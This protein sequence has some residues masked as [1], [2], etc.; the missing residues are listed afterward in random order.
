MSER[1]IKFIPGP[2]ADFLMTK[3]YC[4]ALLALVA[5]RARREPG[6]P[7]GLEPGEA[8]I[9]DW[10][11]IGASRQEY[12][13]ALKILVTR[14]HFTVSET[15]R[16]RKKSTTGVTT[17]GTKVK[18]I[19]SSVYDLNLQESNH[20]ANHCPTTAQPLTNHEQERRKNEEER[21]KKRAIVSEKE[22]KIVR[23]SFRSP[24]SYQEDLKNLNEFALAMNLDI[25]CKDFGYWIKKYG[26]EKIDL[27]LSSMLNQKKRVDN[28]ARWMQT[29]LDRDYAGQKENIATN[30]DFTREFQKANNW[31]N[32]T[33][34]KKYCRNEDTQLE[35]YFHLPPEQFKELLK[36]EYKKQENTG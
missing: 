14:K 36:S 23:P 2:E 6:Q 24:P 18:L 28:H 35:Y 9:G 1:F 19:S 21:I 20:Q 16:N 5:Q 30:H 33:I 34:T 25:D 11:A 10:D 4:F 27:H 29:A 8:H 15:N 7:D 22:E 12:R 26:K 17:G 13:T 31:K 3:P 32:L